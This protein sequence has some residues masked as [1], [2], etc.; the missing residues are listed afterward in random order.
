MAEKTDAAAQDT[1]SGGIFPIEELRKQT[2]TDA[3]VHAGVVEKMGW[4]AGKQ[5]SRAEYE[6]AVTAFQ[7]APISR[8]KGK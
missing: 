4:A 3:A 6:A 1:T 5:V 7:A 2:G 8:K